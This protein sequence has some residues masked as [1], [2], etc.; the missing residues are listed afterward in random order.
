MIIAI[1]LSILAAAP[2]GPVL[3][4]ADSYG[5]SFQ[6]TGGVAECSAVLVKSTYARVGSKAPAN[7]WLLTARHCLQDN[8]PAVATNGS[9]HTI[10]LKCDDQSGDGPACGA[11]A[12]ELLDYDVSAIEVR[13]DMFAQGTKLTPAVI[14]QGGTPLYVFGWSAGFRKIAVDTTAGQANCDSERVPQFKRKGRLFYV[15]AQECVMEGDS[16]GAVATNGGTVVGIVRA[17]DGARVD[18]TEIIGGVEKPVPRFLRAMFESCAD[19]GWTREG[20]EQEMA[21]L[22]VKGSSL[23]KVPQEFAEKVLQHLDSDGPWFR[24]LGLVG[25]RDVLVRLTGLEKAAAQRVL[26]G[27]SKQRPE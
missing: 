5:W 14:G 8:K 12:Y 19:R 6:L 11:Y 13:P 7:P 15:V 10:Q 20:C 26:D 21:R 23:A 1:T 17:K 18:V 25:R 16:G 3:E 24:R 2:I 22:G 9:G 27:S 4:A